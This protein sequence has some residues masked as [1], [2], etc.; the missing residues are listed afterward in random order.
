MIHNESAA[1]ATRRPKRTRTYLRIGAFIA[2]AIGLMLMLYG[3]LADPFLIPFQDFAAMPAAQQAD[4]SARAATMHSVR[5][6]QTNPAA[7]EEFVAAGIAALRAG[8]REEARSLLMR[9]VRCLK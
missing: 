8:H 3:T 9:A 7:P 6:D 1:N 2:L 4:Y 5:S